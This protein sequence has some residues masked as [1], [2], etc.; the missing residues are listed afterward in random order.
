MREDLCRASIQTEVK[1]M[2]GKLILAVLM[3][4]AIVDLVGSI[5]YFRTGFGKRFYHDFMG[6]HLPEDNV[7]FDG[8]SFRSKCKHCGKDIMQ[9]S[10]GNWF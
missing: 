4:I 5:I 10:Q 9:D 3:T 2:N 1:K 7:W 8:C 6:C